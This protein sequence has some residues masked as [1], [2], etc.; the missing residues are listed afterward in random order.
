[1]GHFMGDP[2]SY[3]SDEDQA[4]ATQRD[5]IER[6]ETD[7][8]AHG[9]GDDAIETMR[10]TAHDRVDDAIAWAKEQPTPDPDRAYEDA[11]VN[12]PSGVTD[13]EPDFDLAE[14]GGEEP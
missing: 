9:L 1:M 11:F 6:M 2:Q 8:H 10:E 5:S 3:R 13:T 7:L 4:A 12:P 14:T